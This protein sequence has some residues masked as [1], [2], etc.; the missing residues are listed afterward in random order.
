MV[1]SKELKSETPGFGPERKES[2]TTISA[3]PI[4]RVYTP[5]DVAD[6]D[7]EKDVGNPGDYPYL[8]GLHQ[9]GYRGKLWTMRMF[10]GFGGAEET[11]QRFK[12]LLEHGQTGL[13]T[14]FDMPTL[15]GYDTDHP[16]SLGEFGKC[17]V[18]VSSLRDM[19]VLYDGLP[20][21][22]ITT[23]MTINSPAA[24][25]WAMYIAAAEKRGIPAAKLGGTT[26]NDILKEYIAQNEYIFP[27]EPSMRLVVDTIEFATQHLPKWNPV[28]ISGYHIREAGSTAVQEL[29]FTLYDGL[30]YVR[31]CLER[32][33]DIDDF[34]PR[35]S[36]FFNIHNEFFEEIAKFRAARRIWA[37]EMRETFGAKNERSWW[38]R[39]HAQTAGCALTAQ[40]PENNVVRVALQAMAAVLG[41]TNSLHTNGMDEAWAL[42]SEKAAL[43]ALRTQQL[44]AHESGVA[45]TVDPLGGSYF[46]ESLTSQIEE[47]A[48]EY[49]RR[50]DDLGGALPCID[51]GFFVREIA[52][53]SYR[54]QREV[55][56]KE[57]IIVGVNDFVTNDEMDI[58]ILQMD[59]EG[60]RKQ[61]ARL[62]EVRRTRDNREVSR[63]LEGLRQAARVN[64]NLMPYL[65]DAV[66]AY[67]TLGET[68]DVL[69]DVFGVYE[70]TWGA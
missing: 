31:W 54:F 64:K 62:A 59:Q 47:G 55:E 32:G 67:A 50:I 40:Q 48:R 2:F 70:P 21:D 14:A 49:F 15:Y 58:P 9:T 13:S 44:I 3:L 66:K 46:V 63:T 33:L 10:A 38:M 51:N 25:I 36:F 16:W 24:I 43:L 20:L 28:S 17:G 19:E 7:Y 52:D 56:D 12:Y 37:H 53:A 57:R 1:E 39:T 34:A 41:G 35:L 68:M 22:T 45:N 23:S 27:P 4:E 8:R 30:E 29:A 6:V 65:V 42:P 26:Q 5:E 69:R 60:E 11:N 61:I 18:A